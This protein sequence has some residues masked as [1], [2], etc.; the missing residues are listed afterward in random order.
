MKIIIDK[1]IA[2]T[3]IQHISQVCD[4]SNKQVVM[5]VIIDKGII[6]TNEQVIS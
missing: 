6:G 1:D 3:A 2:D 4:N 5:K